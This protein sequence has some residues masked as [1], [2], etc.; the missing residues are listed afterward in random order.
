[1]AYKER[2]ENSKWNASLNLSNSE[3]SS[4]EKRFCSLHFIE[5]NNDISFETFGR[6]Q[7]LNSDILNKVFD[8]LFENCHE[9]SFQDY[10]GE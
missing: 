2:D 10:F 8:V 6:N 9:N 4:Q 3:I 5:E 7:N 1:M